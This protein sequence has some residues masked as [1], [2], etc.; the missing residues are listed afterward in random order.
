MAAN[1]CNL[2]YI[3]E[4]DDLIPNWLVNHWSNITES[5]ERWKYG[6][7][8]SAADQQKFFAI[9]INRPG[10]I[11]FITDI[12]EIGRTFNEMWSAEGLP[13]II[14]D[15]RINRVH[16][17]HINGTIPSTHTLSI[18]QDWNYPNYWTLLFYLDGEDG[19]TV[20]YN[21]PNLDLGETEFKEV[22]RVKFKRG[23]TLFFPSHYWH[24]GELP[25]SGFRKSI[26][27]N[28]VL[29]D[30]EINLDIQKQRGIT[31]C[32]QPE[33]DIS[34]FLSEMDAFVKTHKM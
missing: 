10:E 21:E 5:S 26:S 25:S 27:I 7:R 34:D 18:H 1:D 32:S 22:H 20:F 28:Y 13:S 2:Q 6:L 4:V 23:R 17:C 11:P 15:A 30:C 9:W 31:K 33:P 16:R 8:G 29:H 19:D 14:P 24:V 12:C 3:F